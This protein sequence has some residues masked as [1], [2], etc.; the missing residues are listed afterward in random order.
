MDQSKFPLIACITS[1]ASDVMWALEKPLSFKL[2]T[3][4][5]VALASVSLEEEIFGPSLDPACTKVPLNQIVKPKA[6]F[7]SKGL[8]AASVQTND[9]SLLNLKSKTG[10]R[11]FLD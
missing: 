9:I 6:D 11:A 2:S 7:P 8:K 3:A 5:R 10:F 4:K 1:S